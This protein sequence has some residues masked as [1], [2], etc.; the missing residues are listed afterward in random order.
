[1]KVKDTITQCFPAKM[2]QNLTYP[3]S[4]AKNGNFYCDWQTM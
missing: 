4:N 2:G 3:Y 1:M